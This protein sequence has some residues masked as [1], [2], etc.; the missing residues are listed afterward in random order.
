[1]G[2]VPIGFLVVVIA[3]AAF[4]QYRCN[5]SELAM[6]TT[7]IHTEI[8]EHA[9]ACASQVAYVIDG[10]HRTLLHM[11]RRLWNELARE[12]GALTN[13]QLVQEFESLADLHA[14]V[15]AMTK[16]TLH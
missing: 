12:R 2:S 1:M 11:M 7:G 3:S 14:R 9:A 5:R 15:I 4:F 6:V 13:A 8:L 16:P 10:S